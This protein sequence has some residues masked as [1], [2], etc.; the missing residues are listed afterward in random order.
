MENKMNFLENGKETLIRI[1][2]LDRDKAFD[3]IGKHLTNRLDVNDYGFSIEAMFLDE[4][5]F[6]LA[7]EREVVMEVIEEMRRHEE[8]MENIRRKLK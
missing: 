6:Q 2:V 8:A 5:R 1:K 3:F 4:D 7:V